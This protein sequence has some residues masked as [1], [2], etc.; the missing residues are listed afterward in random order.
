MNNRSFVTVFA[1]LAAGCSSSSS[2]TP[3]GTTDTD[4]GH[5][6]A[7]SGTSN[8][9]GSD[10]GNTGTVDASDAGTHVPVPSAVLIV[11]TL[12]DADLT[13]A[14]GKHDPVAKGGEGTSKMLG[15]VAHTVMLGTALLGT[16]QNQFVAFD[17]WSDGTN[18]DAFYGSKDFQ[19]ALGPLF[20]APPKTN[21]FVAQPGWSSYGTPDSANAADPHYWV[22][23]RGKMKSADPKV[24][25]AT[26]DGIASQAAP[27]AKAAGD[28]A[29][30]VYTGRDD[31]Q[32]FLAVDVWPDSTNIEAFYGN[33]NVQMAFGQLFDGAPT[34]AVYSSTHWYQW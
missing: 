1:L 10:A 29:H 20:S 30:V 32:Q 25:Q 23:V 27:Q 7:D 6:A 31:V 24:N 13:V 9:P 4:A 5:V 8:E 28:V 17:R 22:L 26:H 21:V 15:D 11:G 19:N 3:V 16:Q 2:G 14:Q 33:P 18:I 12:A 34:I